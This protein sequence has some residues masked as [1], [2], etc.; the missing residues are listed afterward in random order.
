MSVVSLCLLAG[1]L[2]AFL[3][4][5]EFFH[6]K[7]E[8]HWF[9]EHHK[10]QALWN[11]FPVIFMPRCSVRQHLVYAQIPET[12]LRINHVAPPRR[13]KEKNEYKEQKRISPQAETHTAEVISS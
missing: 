6:R 11:V 1:I 8:G 10:H 9:M 7:Q 4:S 12:V 13:R 2:L 5:K 3:F